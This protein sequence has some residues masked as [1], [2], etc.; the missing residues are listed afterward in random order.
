MMTGI[1]SNSH[2]Q[3]A[4]ECKRRTLDTARSGLVK[5]MYGSC[6]NYDYAESR[7][8]PK[9]YLNGKSDTD[10]IDMVILRGQP[11]PWLCNKSTQQSEQEVPQHIA[12][13][14]AKAVGELKA[15]AATYYNSGVST[16]CKTKLQNEDKKG[17]VELTPEEKLQILAA[18]NSHREALRDF[19]QNMELGSTE[20]KELQ[21][22]IRD[23]HA[24]THLGVG[25]ALQCHM[26]DTQQY[27]FSNQKKMKA[28]SST[29]FPVTVPLHERKHLISFENIQSI[30]QQAESKSRI[31]RSENQR[32]G[33]W[34]I[35]RA[36]SL[37]FTYVS[38]KVH[39]LLFTS[40]ANSSTDNQKVLEQLSGFDTHDKSYHEG[41]LPAPSSPI[42]GQK[43]RLISMRRF[44]SPDCSSNETRYH[45]N[46]QERRVRII[47][48]KKL[49]QN[50]V[51]LFRRSISGKETPQNYESICSLE[52]CPSTT[53]PHT[54]LR[55][56]S[57]PGFMKIEE[58]YVPTKE[59]FG[60][61]WMDKSKIDPRV[62]NN[63]LFEID[64]TLSP[65]VLLDQSDLVE[66][67]VVDKKRSYCSNPNES[68]S[69]SPSGS[70]LA[71]TLT[72]VTEYRIFEILS[73]ATCWFGSNTNEVGM[74]SSKEPLV[75][76]PRLPLKYARKVTD[77]YKS[78]IQVESSESET[79][80]NFSECFEEK[81]I[82]VKSKRISESNDW[83]PP[84]P[85]NSA[86]F[87]KKE[88]CCSTKSSSILESFWSLICWESRTSCI[89][90]EETFDL[91]S[92]FS[93]NS[94]MVLHL[95]R[96]TLTMTQGSISVTWSNIFEIL[97]DE[98]IESQVSIPCA[99]ESNLSHNENWLL[100]KPADFLDRCHHAIRRRSKQSEKRADLLR[101][102]AFIFDWWVAP[103]NF[104]CRLNSPVKETS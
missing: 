99:K 32:R 50:H 11:M 71:D 26:V 83:Q 31:S 53:S 82:P 9:T 47:S 13:Q 48:P 91:K 98:Y 94:E 37:T 23:S 46:H 60:T 90:E 87:I 15:V 35:A 86:Q 77:Q 40:S 73:T 4:Y 45:I 56:V 74:K 30:K 95:H 104:L 88:T 41:C 49:N 85:I 97:F 68:R 22:L 59:S 1:A 2:L 17:F 78:Q 63:F 34:R 81:W 80:Q 36:P 92:I 20:W 57:C 5:F 33:R 101:W 51:S 76:C 27:F 89:N 7:A 55:R 12:R 62:S 70:L 58:S 16:S 28:K 102:I 6:K 21:Q 44:S 25:M 52:R 14:F 66:W 84:V 65:I 24:Y 72:K 67:R 93:V 64:M 103:L 3:R 29:S 39:C 43:T 75:E 42:T 100:D 54:A 79:V 10:M 19:V 69:Q 8:H 18:I 96:P 38:N 61:N